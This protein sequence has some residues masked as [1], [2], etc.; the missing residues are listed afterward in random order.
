[1]PTRLRDVLGQMW[2]SFLRPA[3]DVLTEK[4]S[5]S[6]PHPDGF[7]ITRNRRHNR[8]HLNQS[9][10]EGRPLVE[11]GWEVNTSY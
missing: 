5:A 1:M 6:V 4:R 8:L 2:N 11:L 3:E 7:A 10:I 9:N